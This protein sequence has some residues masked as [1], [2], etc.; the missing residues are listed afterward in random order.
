MS[1]IDMLLLQSAGNRG[2]VLHLF[3]ALNLLV[4]SALQSGKGLWRCMNKHHQFSEFEIAKQHGEPGWPPQ[5]PQRQPPQQLDSGNCLENRR[6]MLWGNWSPSLLALWLLGG[7]SSITL[8]RI[9]SQDRISSHHVL[10]GGFHRS[11]FSFA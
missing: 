9:I 2:G 10:C 8:A 3:D 5:E 6:S 7:V 1:P 4:P 11:N